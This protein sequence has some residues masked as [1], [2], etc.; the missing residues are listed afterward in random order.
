MGTKDTEA[1]IRAELGEPRAELT[2]IGPGGDLV[3]EAA[4]DLGVLYLNIIDVE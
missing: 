1:A 4:R 3:K 2:L